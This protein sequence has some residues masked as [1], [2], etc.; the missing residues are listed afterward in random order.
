[1]SLVAIIILLSA[2]PVFLVIGSFVSGTRKKTVQTI[3]NRAIS[4]EG[5]EYMHLKDVKISYWF[6]NGNRHYP[7]V[8]NTGDIFIFRDFILITRKQW[9]LISY[10]LKPIIISYG[11]RIEHLGNFVQT[12]FPKRFSYWEQ[13]RKEVQIQLGFRKHEHLSAVLSLKE[14]DAEQINQ[15]K[16]F[17]RRIV[18][19]DFT[20]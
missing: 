9:F 12:T 5:K 10:W 1:M 3:I 14:L 4:S 6:S 15:L 16:S 13:R 2:L 7:S 17:E 11:T 20:A 18:P 19:I 8:N